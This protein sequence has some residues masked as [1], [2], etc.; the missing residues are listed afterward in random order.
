MYHSF[1][2]HLF[3]DGHLGY[4]QKFWGFLF[5]CWNPWLLGL[6][7]SQVVL[8]SLSACKCGTTS[9][10][11]TT[12]PFHPVCWSP[13]L[14]SIPPIS[15][16]ECFFFN[17]LVVR[18]PYSSIFCQ[19]WLFFVFKFV[20][21]LFWLCEEAECVYLHLHLGWKLSKL[22]HFNYDVSWSGPLCIHLA[23]DSVC[24]LDL[25]VYFLHQIREVFFYYFFK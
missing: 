11:L 25:H 10:C 17:S 1:L 7:P 12:C 18:L 23:W 22:W 5:P 14:L 16:D 19:F 24:F 15:L 8:P 21:V 3:T 13:P 20:V 2:I 6:S 4:S 9:H